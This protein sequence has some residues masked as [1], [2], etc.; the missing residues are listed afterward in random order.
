[1]AAALMAEDV[2][3]D[4]QGPDDGRGGDKVAVE[5]APGGGELPGE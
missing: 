2:A 3:E 5:D 1:M 4:A